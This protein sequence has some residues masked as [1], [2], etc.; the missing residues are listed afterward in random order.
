MN[1]QNHLLLGAALLLAPLTSTLAQSTWP[2]QTVDGYIAGPSGTA[3][4]LAA[5]DNGV[6]FSARSA[7]PDLAGIA[8]AYVRRSLDGGQ[9]WELVSD[10]PGNGTAS[11]L[12]VAVGHYSGLVFATAIIRNAQNLTRDDWVTLRSADGGTTWSKVDVLTSPNLKAYPYSVVEDTAGRVFV[13]GWFS[14]AANRDHYLV[15][16]SLNGGTTWATVDDLVGPY[17]GGD[18]ATGMAATPAGVFSVGRI[19]SV[20]SVRRSTNGGTTWTTVDSY[21]SVPGR[22]YMSWPKG[23]AADANGSLYVTGTAD[24]PVNKATQN[25]WI[26]RKSSDGGTTWR[27]VDDFLPGST[28]DA[29]AVTA[30]AFGRVFVTGSYFTGSGPTSTQHWITRASVDGGVTWT[31]TDD[32]GGFGMSATSDA[33]GNVYIGGR[34]LGDS[35][36][37]SATVRKL[38]AP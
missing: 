25:R 35:T 11:S 29:R 15:R 18:L 31:T 10:Q 37:P 7:A 34:S 22:T 12:A 38:A 5:V 2:W 24:F 28:P 20:W 13:G 16:R 1:K 27:T 33:I 14:D 32:L 4:G 23:I 8:H 3:F 6:V 30:D 19:A 36:S 21:Q 9:T 17:A 26:T